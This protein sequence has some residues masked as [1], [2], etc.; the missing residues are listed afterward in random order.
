MER[1]DVAVIGGGPA[2][3]AAARAA[4]V[5][6]ASAVVLERGVPR[7]DRPGQLGPDST[8]AAGILDYWVDI[9]DIDPEE[10]PDDV[11]LD[12]LDQATF[13]G[14]TESLT[15][16]STG[17][18]SSYDNFGFC[19]H[20]A[21][22]D[23]FLRE[24]AEDA[25]ATYR[26]GTAV[27]D[28]ETSAN[29]ITATDGG[30]AA[31]VSHATNAGPRHTIQLAD[32][33][34]IGASVV[35]LA[36][37]P[38]RQ[39]T[40]RVLDT[41][42][43]FDVTDRLSTRD[44]NHIAYQEHRELPAAVAEEV[45]RSILFWWGHMPGHTA[46]PWIFPND[47]NIARIG[48][49]MPIGLTLDEVSDPDSYPLLNADD[50]Q[51][52]RGSEYIE[53]LLEQEYG[54]RYDIPEDFPLVESRGK[55]NGTETYAISS[56]RPID[57]PAEAGILVVGGA[58]GTTSAFH[59]GGDHTAMRTGA[60]AGE[61][62]ATGE[63][64][65]YNDRWKDAIGDEILRNVA[66][67][68]IVREYEPDDWDWAFKTAQSLLDDSTKYKLLDI[69]NLTAGIGAARLLTRYKRTKFRYRNDR[70]VQIRESEYVV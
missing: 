51:L 39:V 4:A 66:M 26:V 64:E 25:G 2:G 35:I 29:Q 49:T 3:A 18:D 14:P 38:Q 21:R 47:G 62:A 61:V 65:S 70:Y 67:A 32:N 68:D 45:S 17:I 33:T 5:N 8:D 53:R 13:I 10:F 46:Y 55:D 41:Y 16:E 24:R 69:N 6:G 44:A 27:R 58:M 57:S 31:D 50:E 52:P 9:M 22:F 7:A 43:S 15:L 56:T 40:N 60:I 42:L 1:F 20:R 34:N 28:V 48:L 59:E 12:E 23:D 19:M 54:D 63:L 36:D 30:V 11:I 37:G